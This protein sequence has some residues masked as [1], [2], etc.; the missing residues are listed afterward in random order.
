MVNIPVIAKRELNTYFLSLMAYLVLTFFALASGL[1]FAVIIALYGPQVDPNALIGS[2]FGWT[3]YWIVLAV[4]LIT[5]RLLSEEA[6]SGTVETLMTAPVS[7]AEVVLGKY[8]GAL[9]FTM[10]LL[11]PVALQCL[12]VAGLGP[13]DYGP[14][15]AGWLGLYLLVAQF[16]AIGLLCSALF[17]IQLASGLAAFLVLFG[18][19]LAGVI[20]HGSESALAQACRYLSPPRHLDAMM[21]G[22]IDSR[23]LV[24]FVVTTCLFLFLSVRA[25]ESRKWR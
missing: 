5:M 17:R 6:S 23:D 11:A 24:Y 16:L 14:L 18:L 10:V 2:I 1:G 9:I 4:P 21:K 15:A 13:L 19:M 12:Y 7:D 8:V 20:A 25:L 22:I 3:G